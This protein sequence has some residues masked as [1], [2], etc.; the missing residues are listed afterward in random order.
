MISGSAGRRTVMRCGTTTTTHPRGSTSGCA[1]VD[2]QPREHSSC[3]R[4]VTRARSGV[5]HARARPQGLHGYGVPVDGGPKTRPPGV[6]DGSRPIAHHDAGEV[7]TDEHAHDPKQQTLDNIAAWWPRSSM[8]MRRL[9]RSKLGAR[10]CEPDHRRVIDPPAP[11]PLCLPK[12]TGRTCGPASEGA[13]HDERGHSRGF[14]D[15]RRRTRGGTTPGPRACNRRSRR[16]TR[17]LALVDAG[18]GRGG[19][20]AL[21]R[22]PDHADPA[23]TVDSRSDVVQGDTPAAGSDATLLAPPT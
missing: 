18:G 21:I 10:M 7:G 20:P 15:R 19:A 9:T 13:D 12:G 14:P 23:A 2:E 1:R 11:W 6:R 17:W 8:S 22:S 16:R 5:Q 4:A 3:P